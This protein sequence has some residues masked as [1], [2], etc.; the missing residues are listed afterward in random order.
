MSSAYVLRFESGERQGETIPLNV[1]AGAPFTIGRLPGNSLQVVETSVSS[2]HAQLVI[3]DDGVRLDDLDSTNGMRV[4]GARVRTAILRHG[5]EFSLGNV[6]MR[7]IQQDQPP[8]SDPALPSLKPTLRKGALPKASEAGLARTQ[9]QPREDGLE[10]SAADLARSKQSSKFGL[11]ALAGLAAAAGGAW[12]WLKG[13][14]EDS[15]RAEARPARAPD[16]DLLAAGFS[17][18]S[19]AGWSADESAPS[20]FELSSSA[21]VS[22]RTGLLATLGRAPLP[23]EGGAG[24]GPPPAAAGPDHALHLSEFARVRRGNRVIAGAAVRTEG[25]AHARLGVRFEGSGETPPTPCEVWSDAITSTVGP[26]QFALPTVIP[27]GYDRAQLRL[28]AESASGAG[29]VAIDDASLVAQSV[30]AAGGAIERKIGTWEIVGLGGDRVIV[31]AKVDR[32][33]V[34]C[35]RVSRVGAAAGAG[36]QG[37]ATE[38]DTP[39]MSIALDELGFGLGAEDARAL[40]FDVEPAQVIGGI[41]TLG[42]SGYI[43]HSANF[44]RSDA[45]DLLLGKDSDLV[46]LQLPRPMAVRG[47]SRGGGSAVRIELAAGERVRWQLAF[48]TERVQAQ[49]LAREARNAQAEGRPSDGLRAWNQLLA[50]VPFDQVLVDEAATARGRLVQGGLAELGAL[51]RDLERARF[52][53]LVDLYDELMARTRALATRF[54]GSEVESGAEE[55]FATLSAERK[56][57]AQDL[58]RYER[59]R[60]EAI[61][62]FLEGSEAPKLAREVRDYLAE[63]AQGAAPAGG[64]SGQPGSSPN[65]GSGGGR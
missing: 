64:K 44:E 39:Q 33:F 56:V 31:L 63:R 6:L 27:P 5:A 37:A 25:A 22:G 57:L 21:R 45:T 17:F 43:A 60:L 11:I 10:I 53:R 28:A 49:R 36:P 7:L 58:D 59:S 50:E 12:F 14:G 23:D 16:G 40:A 19:S 8:V 51:A 2:R 52:F 35:L 24:Q 34:T 41:A 62:A 1:A 29:D 20:V 26:E 42:A 38:R 32:V 55:L 47:V 9:V 30:G 48:D 4:D 13:R 54:A 15:P 46:R 61:A 65:A 18:E 3:E